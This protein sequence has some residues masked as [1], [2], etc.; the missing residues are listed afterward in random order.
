VLPGFRQVLQEPETE[1]GTLTGLGP[2]R[3]TREILAQLSRYAPQQIQTL[4]F[5]AAGAV[6]PCAIA[7]GQGQLGV[8]L[9]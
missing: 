3:Q 1:G 8:D 6:G 5:L 2:P 7:L 9:R 4:L